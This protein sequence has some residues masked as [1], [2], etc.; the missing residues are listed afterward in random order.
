MHASIIKYYSI[1]KSANE[2]E[3]RL[4]MW[5]YLYFAYGRLDSKF[6][7]L[8]LK[9]IEGIC[10]EYLRYKCNIQILGIFQ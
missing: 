7:W 5:I 9:F 8:R 4:N 2:F 10:F 3:Y 6:H 1:G